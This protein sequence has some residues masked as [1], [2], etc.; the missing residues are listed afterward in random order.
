MGI[1]RLILA[2]SVVIAHAGPI[3]G[4]HFVGGLIAV[5]TFFIISGFYMSMVLNEKYTGKNNSYALFISNR[6]L[7][8]FPI[9][10]TILL[11]TIITCTVVAFRDGVANT[12]I[13]NQY[14]SINHSFTSLFFLIFTNLLIFGQ[15]AV[16]F[17]G[18]T[19][20]S[21]NLFF[22]SDFTQ[23]G[24]ALYHSLFVPQAWSLG[25]EMMFYVL[26]PFILKKGIKPVLALF[27]VSLATKLYIY[28]GLGFKHDPWIYRF[29]P[30]ELMFFL[31]GYLSYRLLKF[32]ETMRIPSWVSALACLWVFA[33][34][35]LYSKIPTMGFSEWHK[36][37]LYYVGVLAALPLVFRIFKH[38]KTDA[39]IG[40]L[41]Y[42]IYISHIF[43]IL[44]VQSFGFHL[45][46]LTV[47]MGTL[48][49]SILLNHFI[50]A[51]IE[52]LRQAR[53]NRNSDPDH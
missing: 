45:S 27:A 49:L 13:F 32:T 30:A 42:P 35:I 19:P 39:W 9:Y 23:T 5:K 10:W 8:L 18:I 16:M 2:L 33:F 37:I 43:I 11:L 7:R 31:A 51:P 38:L 47:T 3:A 36:E 52:K 34:T 12:P 1:L 41:S 28:F 22:T 17:M 29:F 48:G 50:A 24:P 40:E 44:C 15:D 4:F 25:L 20:E 6:F 53:I 26:A 46:G 21:G 14:Y